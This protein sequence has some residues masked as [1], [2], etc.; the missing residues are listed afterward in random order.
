MKNKIFHNSIMKKPPD[1]VLPNY[2]A[3]KQTLSNVVKH[4]HIQDVLLK[5]VLSAH[6]IVIHAMQFMKMYL[7]HEYDK[8]GKLT[9]IDHAFVSNI[10]KIICE[11]SNN[12]NN[13]KQGRPPN[14]KTVALKYTLQKFYN[15]HYKETITTNEVLSYTHMN[16]ILD[17]LTI[18]TI[19]IYETNIKQHYVEYVERFINILFEQKQK[20]SNMTKDETNVFYSKLRKIKNTILDGNKDLP[21]ELSEHI[22]FIIPQ[23]PFKKDNMYYDIQCSPQDYLPCMIYMMK[24]IESKDESIKNVFPLRSDIIPKYI[25]IDTTTL[26]HLLITKKQG[27]KEEFLTEGNLIKRQSEIWKY[28]F[29]TEK[30]YFSSNNYIFNYMIETDGIACSILLVRKDVAGKRFKPTIKTEK[31]YY[32]DDVDNS[33]LKNKNIVA[34]DPN[35]SDL[36]YCISKQ[37]DEILHFRYTQDQK[38]KET[39]DKKYRN[40]RD[41][42]K[43]TTIINN[44]T[45]IEWET[46]LSKFNRKT[47][48][49]DKYKAY[50][51]K[52]NEVN[53]YLLSF[54]EQKIFRKLKWNTFMNRK[55][56]EHKMIN[57]FKEKFGSSSDTIIGFGDWEQKKQMK[58]K[59]PTKGIGM[60]NLFRKAGYQV[61]LVD[62]FRTSCRCSKCEGECVKFKECQNPR[63]WKKNET[64]LRHGLLMCKTC[65]GLWNRDVNSSF[66]IFK[67][68]ENIIAGKERP[69]YLQRVSN[70]TSVLQKQILDEDEKPQ[71]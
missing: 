38:R 19:T 60:R 18:D 45:I 67:I 12:T 16:T 8:N 63:P 13:K 70:T 66:N 64:I 65:K 53:S 50:C 28:F 23:R 6:K 5:T 29:H 51:K 10:M 47:L 46:E 43:K 48:Q 62:E 22:K 44:K 69:V 31:E 55:R 37:N 36:I 11:E 56:S 17:Y 35:K 49:L 24:F 2:R 26:V 40:I 52:K 57:R 27:S 32:I 33:I 9:I 20:V 7:I 21:T 42:L 3:V 15:E 59:E 71:L 39:K 61:Y 25:R 1:K 41:E 58:Y 54:Y 68:V 14:S 34:I 4:K 30:S